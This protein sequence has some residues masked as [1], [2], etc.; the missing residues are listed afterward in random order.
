MHMH[1]K[2]SIIVV[3]YRNPDSLARC[4]GSIERFGGLG[5]VT[6]EVIVVKNSDETLDASSMPAEY[7]TVIQ[8]EQNQGFGAAVNRAAKIAR[9]SHLLLLNPDAELRHDSITKLLKFLGEH[10]EASIV[11]MR[12]ESSNGRT[13]ASFGNQPNVLREVAALTG[14]SRILPVGR[15]IRPTGALSGL[16]QR[17][18]KRG[19]VG[20]GAACINA[21]VFRAFGGFNEDFFLYVEDVELCRRVSHAGGE[22]WFCAEAVVTHDDGASRAATRDRSAAQRRTT[23]GLIRYAE[24]YGQPVRALRAVQ[25]FKEMV[26]A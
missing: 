18:G 22:V 16:Y 14:L 24:I 7:L 10:E 3:S 9:G 6:R 12:Q 17:S 1:P 19:W 23:E 13:V 25:S 20:G 11:G 15:L 5:S 4:L 26:R 21:D 8:N 2:L